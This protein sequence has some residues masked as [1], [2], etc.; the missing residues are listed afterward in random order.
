[1]EQTTNKTIINLQNKDDAAAYLKKNFAKNMYFGEGILGM[2]AN[3]IWEGKELTDKEQTVLS[4]V[5][6]MSVGSYQIGDKVLKKGTCWNLS[7]EYPDGN[8]NLE[9]G[10]LTME[11]G[12][13]IVCRGKVLNLTIGSLKKVMVPGAPHAYYDFGIF[14]RDG[15]NGS[16]GSNGSA[17]NNGADGV[18][19]SVWS[20]GIAG[21]DGK[22]GQNGAPGQ[23]GRDGTSGQNGQSVL[24]ATI[25]IKDLNDP[26]T[27]LA[28]PGDGGNGGKGGDGGKGG[29]GGKGGDGCDT[30]CEGSDG[31]NGGNGGNGGDGGNG[32]NGGDGGCGGTVNVFVGKNPN[33]VNIVTNLSEGGK[34]GAKGIGGAVGE[35]GAKG[36]GGKHQSDGNNGSNGQSVGANGAPGNDGRNGT[37]PI[38]NVSEM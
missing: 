7:N 2:M 19:G 28:K 37:A 22:D 10:T 36:T 16:N 5:L 32:G 17:G 29:N 18:N 9:I 14:G 35:G 12:S 25:R 34:G 27:I 24:A 33:M 8:I 3:R 11:S 6:P 20:P 26:L 23:A 4:T 13:S 31:G 21:D 38:I 15:A 30:G 1:M